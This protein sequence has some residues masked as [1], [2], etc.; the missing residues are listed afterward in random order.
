MSAYT[1][2]LEGLSMKIVK[3]VSQENLV[4]RL[5][6]LQSEFSN[7]FINYFKNLE[8]K[9]QDMLESKIS[10]K[11]FH[12]K[13]SLKVE[14]S[15]FQQLSV[16]VTRMKDMVE[17][18][19]SCLLFA[20][21]KGK[22]KLGATQENIDTDT[23]YHMEMLEKLKSNSAEQ[24]NLMEN[25]LLI[26]EGDNCNL[27]EKLGEQQILIDRI[28]NGESNFS[29]SS[30]ENE[31]ENENVYSKFEYPSDELAH[32]PANIY[33]PESEQAKLDERIITTD[34]P[35]EEMQ[36]T[37]ELHSPKHYDT[38]LSKFNEVELN[39]ESLRPKGEYSDI[40]QSISPSP[41]TVNHEIV[42][43]LAKRSPSPTS[44]HHHSKISKMMSFTQTNFAKMTSRFS[45]V[46]RICEANNQRVVYIYIYIYTTTLV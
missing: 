1:K 36:V 26:I 29:S 12:T 21:S 44:K 27:H 34:N 6:V 30:G 13:L 24:M 3:S 35:R 14:Q 20:D 22:Q 45:N 17:H 4:Y 38:K 25:R 7:Q 15:S 2:C 23:I 31:N 41:K 5:K 11:E 43:D 8:K 32:I 19:H 37:Q 16:D 9:N 33:S 46:D 39:L 18:M 42:L 10:I 40:S 28:N